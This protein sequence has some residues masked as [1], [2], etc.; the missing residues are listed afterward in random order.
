[1]YLRFRILAVA[2]FIRA[3][4]IVMDCT[5]SMAEWINA[6]RDTVIQTAEQIRTAS[7][8]SE[9]RL[10]FIG[11]RDH[12]DND[13]I[14]SVPFTT[15]IAAVQ[16]RIR[17]MSAAGGNDTPEDVAGGLHAALQLAWNPSATSVVL[18][19][20]DAPAH[21]KDWHDPALDDEYPQG[22][23]NGRDPY[24]LVAAL[25]ERKID[26]TV[27]K[28]SDNM[29]V[30]VKRFLAAHAEGAQRPSGAGDDANFVI[31][32]VVQQLGSHRH[33]PA[34]GFGFP[35]FGAFG[36]GGF[37]GGGVAPAA[38]LGFPSFGAVGGGVGCSG[39][40]GGGGSFS[41]G[42][43]GDTFS[44]G[45]SPCAPSSALFG[46]AAPASAAGDM[47]TPQALVFMSEASASCARSAVSRATYESRTRGDTPKR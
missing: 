43:G 10:A 7:V 8:G 37:G 32:N 41:F 4:C 2:A 18:F 27:F 5:G 29:D 14:V 42:G 38:G 25:A 1:M 45:A 47:L 30:M 22:D 26:M 13:Q 33:A 6:A 40:G 31:L 3:V 44:F 46:A 17:A 21:G 36:G 24:Q 12:G 16:A 28:C 23:P 11:Y 19:V 34:A 9:F 20:A 15:D 39:F 35:S